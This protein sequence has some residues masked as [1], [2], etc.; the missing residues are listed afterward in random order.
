M[1]ADNRVV[2][3]AVVALTAAAAGHLSGESEANAAPCASFVFPGPTKV[4]IN[5]PMMNGAVASFN[6]TG[7]R[8]DGAPGTLSGIPIAGNANGTGSGLIDGRAISLGFTLTGAPGQTPTHLD[9]DGTIADD[10]SASGSVMDGTW[11]LLTPLKC[12]DAAQAPPP[13]APAKTQPG[14][15]SEQVIGGLVIHVENKNDDTT[16]CHYD[17]EIVDRDFT[18]NPKQTTD[19]RIVPALPL[20]RDWNYSITCDNDTSTSGKIF[21]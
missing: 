7:K 14:V 11:R 18:L 6:A 10:G 2:W 21:F 4:E 15:T 13:A 1:D 19:I 16:G 8:S 5:G 12:A 20:F 17:S 3:S 9:M